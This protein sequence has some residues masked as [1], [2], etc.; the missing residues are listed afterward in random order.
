L[1]DLGNVELRIRPSKPFGEWVKTLRLF[2]YSVVGL[3]LSEDE[4][5]EF[6]GEAGH[7][8]N[9]FLRNPSVRL[10]SVDTCALADAAKRRR[11]PSLLVVGLA[12][13]V[14]AVDAFLGAHPNRV[15]ALELSIAEVRSVYEEDPRRAF[16]WTSSLARAA[17]ARGTPIVGSS[18]ASVPGGLI[19]P[20]T[21][22]AFANMLKT[23][24]RSVGI[25][26]RRFLRRLE[27]IA[28]TRPVVSES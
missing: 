28:L 24:H 10:P 23:N 13:S 3:D 26:E 15:E 4:A 5:L 6:Q 25:R 7:E 2:G 16:E 1:L 22:R 12:D 19:T 17:G 18:S 20:L 14:D 8:L 11:P 27:Q 21:K 9:C